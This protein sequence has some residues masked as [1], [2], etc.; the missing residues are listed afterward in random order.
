M[1]ISTLLGASTATAPSALSFGVM[2]GGTGNT[3][4]SGEGLE[5]LNSFNQLLGNFLSLTGGEGVTGEGAPLPGLTTDEVEAGLSPGLGG[6]ALPSG[7]GAL[8]GGGGLNGLNLSN[9][10]GTGAA[11]KGM[12]ARWSQS[13]I[14]LLAGGGLTGQEMN[15]EVVA[16]LNDLSTVFAAAGP[17][18]SDG[19]VDNVAVAEGETQT[20]ETDLLTVLQGGNAAAEAVLV[21]QLAALTVNSGKSSAPVIPTLTTDTAPSALGVN[22]T[23]AGTGMK[24]LPTV[25]VND[26]GPTPSPM[27]APVIPKLATAAPP[28]PVSAGT[29]TSAPAIPKAATKVDVTPVD[30]Q[31]R[32][33]PVMAT[34][35]GDSIDTGNDSINTGIVPPQQP[36]AATLAPAATPTPVSTAAKPATIGTT[37]ISTTTANN[38]TV[39]TMTVTA[40]PAPT[41]PPS[42]ATT[43]PS[44]TPVPTTTATPTMVTSGTDDG[45]G[46]IALPADLTSAAAPDDQASPPAPASASAS[47]PVKAAAPAP[48]VSAAPPPPSLTTAPPPAQ[49]TPAP[50]AAPISGTP[51]DPVRSDVTTVE[52]NSEGNAAI[53]SAPTPPPVTLTAKPVTQTNA[54]APPVARPVETAGTVTPATADPIPEAVPADAEA[55]VEAETTVSTTTGSQVATAPARPA[56]TS[57]VAATTRPPAMVRTNAEAA[58]VDADAGTEPQVAVEEDG[59]VTNNRMLA[60]KHVGTDAQV[61]G[62]ADMAGPAQTAGQNQPATRTEAPNLRPQ[63]E[64]NLLSRAVTAGA[65]GQEGGSA[66]DGD[67]G[68]GSGSGFAEPAAADSTAAAVAVGENGKVQSSDFA[69]SLRQTSGPHRP[70]AYVPPGHQMAM[71]VQR[72]VQD[73]NDRVSIQLNPYELGRIDVQLE[74]GSEGKLRAKVMVENPQT[75]EMLQKDAKNLEKALQEAGL[76]TDKDSL[77]F[78]LQDSGDQAQQRQDQQEQSGYG[79]GLASDD[80]EEE[81]PAIIAQAQ[82]LEFGR[83]DVRV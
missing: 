44:S 16:F 69:Q 48:V 41:A 29:T 65:R 81:D 58:P 9:L 56:S 28:T 4:P 66:T 32:P 54:A 55:S 33:T 8:L 7:L 36:A 15:P 39:A 53:M 61:D 30:E 22:L 5:G 43:A 60:P 82:I 72:A 63:T 67:S 12:E 45:Q 27:T 75:L 79:T 10:A 52:A 47:A 14:S 70:N 64:D 23:V 3:T 34:A 68:T 19:T 38:A 62:Q 20:P 31:P 78:S 80:V 17:L 2:G 76:Q 50:I 51:T 59:S 49:A 6:A 74:I 1:D 77:S 24:A 40:A 37:T 83:V 21:Q 13:G 25:P 42:V 35:N 57:P 73:G 71:H 46:A 11:P 26:L 18:S